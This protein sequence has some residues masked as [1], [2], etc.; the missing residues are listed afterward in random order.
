MPDARPRRCSWPGDDPRMIDY[1]DRVWGVPVHDDATLF[2]FLLLDGAQAG[3][4]WR[5]ILARWDGYRQA[6]HG[7]DV[8]RIARFGERDV[9]R[10][11]ADPRIIRNRA[12]VHSAV[13]NARATLALRAQGEPLDAFLWRFVDGRPRRNRFRRD[14]EIPAESEESRAMSRALKQRGFRFVGPTICYA[15]MQSAGLVN[16]HLVSCFRYREV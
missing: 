12:K 8:E 7:F 2:A 10:L 5:T 1:H 3:L 11:L 15:F 4:A 13:Q 14:D 6:F 9:E 16:D